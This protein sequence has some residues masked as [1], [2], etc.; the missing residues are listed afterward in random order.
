MLPGA[1]V[2]ARQ[3]QIHGLVSAGVLYLHHISLAA[4]APRE[5]HFAAADGLHWRPDGRAVIRS[6]MRA[7]RFQNWMETRLAEVRSHRRREF[8]RRSQKFFLQRFTVGRV[9]RRLPAGIVKQQRLVP[10]AAIVVLRGQDFS[11]RRRFAVG[12]FFL[13]QYH[14]KGVALAR[15]GVKIQIVAEYLRQPHGQLRRFPALLH[16]AKKRIL[17]PP[18]DRRNLHRARYQ[19]YFR[20]KSIVPGHNF[21]H[22][23]PVNFVIYFAQ[24]PIRG[25]RHG[26]GIARANLAQIERLL[27]SRR[28]AGRLRVGKPHLLKRHHEIP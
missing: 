13:F 20:R 28:S 2:H 27:R 22:P 6:Q 15:I 16:R 24:R 9:V 26:N 8:Q 14:A 25:P 18:A 4:L 7:I 19:F 11:V 5:G 17:D 1:H 3:M 10:L 23:I 21:Q 12:V